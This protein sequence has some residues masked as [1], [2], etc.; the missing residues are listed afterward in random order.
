MFG[1]VLN[2]H[3]AILNGMWILG[4]QYVN[5]TCDGSWF[6]FI[7]KLTLQD[8]QLSID[9]EWQLAIRPKNQSYIHLNLLYY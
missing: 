5:V 7:W 6:D 4:L 3:V 8:S 2:K 1:F 9:Y